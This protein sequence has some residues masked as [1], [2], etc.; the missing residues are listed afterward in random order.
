MQ[1]AVLR[2]ALF[3]VK[4]T[5]KKRHWLTQG[6]VWDKRAIEN[7]YLWV[8]NVPLQGYIKPQVRLRQEGRKEAVRAT[9]KCTDV[10]WNTLIIVQSFLYIVGLNLWL[11]VVNRSEKGESG[12][13]LNAVFCSFRLDVLVCV[14]IFFVIHPTETGGGDERRNDTMPHN[15]HCVY[16]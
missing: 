5:Q 1:K 14:S 4:T 11:I 16:I 12:S 3:I 10:Q 2:R 13:S 7:F 15:V 9:V 8:R 6:E